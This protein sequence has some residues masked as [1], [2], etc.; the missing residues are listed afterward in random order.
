MVQDMIA[1]AINEGLD[2]IAAEKEAIN[3]KITGQRDGFGF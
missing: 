1:M 2:K 3:E